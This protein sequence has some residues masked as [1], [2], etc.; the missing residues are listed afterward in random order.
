M[1][2]RNDSAN[3]AKALFVD[4][5]ENILR[6]VKRTFFRSD[7]D[8]ITAP[9][10]QEGLNILKQEQI[11]IVVADYQMPG[12]DGFHF[13]K[14][15]QK[16]NPQ[17]YRIILSGHVENSAV[18]KALSTGLAM[19]YLTK[20]WDNDEL[21]DRIKQI[22]DRQNRIKKKKLVGLLYSNQ[23]PPTL[24]SLYKELLEAIE[25]EKSMS[26]ISSIIERDL[27]VATR[28]L[29][30]ANS[31]FFGDIKITS[32]KDALVRL[33]LSVIKEVVLTVAIGDTEHWTERFLNELKQIFLHSALVNRHLPIFFR[34]RYGKNIGNSFQSVG[35]TH[36]IGK[37]IL[38]CNMPDRYEMVL[39]KQKDSPGMSFFESEIALGF[40][41]CTHA[42]IGGSLLDYW[43]LPE[44][45]V[46]I[47]LYHH[48]E[49]RASDEFRDVVAATGYT[50]RFVTHIWLSRELE[51]IDLSSLSLPDIPD[52]EIS[53]IAFKI[54]DEMDR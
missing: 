27:V 54:R 32:I 14:R 25:K 21:R 39:K 49:D 37:I 42:E 20:P 16:E 9:N 48:S 31:A 30:I 18:L 24:P 28:V 1:K 51:K 3:S 2:T 7:I 10:A 23:S 40:E 38:L 44:P 46:E 22:L 36:D 41:D 35:I 43:G 29:Q 17:T 4:D 50:D 34:M 47:A 45:L 5:E 52:E 33:G 13:L 11:N 12:M 6:A 8:V 26:D 15:V 19:D 53:E